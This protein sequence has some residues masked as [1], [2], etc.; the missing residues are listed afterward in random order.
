MNRKNS[1][2]E[3]FSEKKVKKFR[4]YKFITILV[5]VLFLLGGLILFEND[6]TVENLRYLVKY[7]DFSSAGAFFEESVIP[8]NADSGNQ[9]FVFRGDLALVNAGGVTLFDRRGSAV[10]TDSFKMS[11]PACV[12]GDRYLAVYDL[13]G[14]QVRIYN[15]FSLL[16]EKTFD[17]MVQSVSVNGDGAFCVVTSKKNYHSAVYVFDRDFKETYQWLSADKYAVDAYLSDQDVLTV[18]A[19]RSEDGEL[20]SDLIELKIGNKDPVST[21]SVKDELPLAHDSRRNGTFLITDKALRWIK[22]GKE[23]RIQTFP[24]GSI[25]KFAMGKKRFAVL[26]DELSVGVNFNL[27]IYDLEMN[28]ISSHKFSVSIRDIEILND[29]VYV[30]THSEL[31]VIRDGKDTVEIPLSEDYLDLGVLSKDSVI[32]CSDTQAEIR[33][34]HL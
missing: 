8:Y 4:V 22:K 9:F 19:I 12:C 11:S 1:N 5:L 32:L 17:Y 33:N 3:T 31:Y 13:G 34:L 14:H 23:E 18:S 25:K 7:L 28:E 21:F 2:A 15:S 20:V 10:M 6:I 30:L 24:D 26:Q 16:Y 27:H 29:T